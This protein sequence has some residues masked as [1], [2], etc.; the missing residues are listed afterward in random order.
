ME[1]AN[2]EQATNPTP[3]VLCI[4][5]IAEERSRIA[6]LFD[7]VGVLVMAS[8][9]DSAS[10]FLRQLNSTSVSQASKEPDGLPRPDVVHVGDLRLDVTH[11]EATWHGE[12]LSLTPH[13][14][15]VL[16]C[17]ARRPGRIWTYQQL[18]DHAWDGPYF[19]GPAAVQSV[20]K[21]L[22][23]KLREAGLPLHIMTA[24]GVGFRLAEGGDLHLVPAGLAS[25]SS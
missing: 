6:G 14:F 18:Y 1:V 13:E 5:D 15:K 19:P 7:G 20:V 16:G 21:R 4:T 12:S 17:L 9:T 22:R 8:D 23:A 11:H 24:R 3:V 10:R 25:S 2:R